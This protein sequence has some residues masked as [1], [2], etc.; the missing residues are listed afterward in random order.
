R[1]LNNCGRI[2]GRRAHRPERGD[3]PRNPPSR[4]AG[5]CQQRKRNQRGKEGLFHGVRNHVA[6][7]RKPS[8]GE[9]LSSLAQPE[10]KAAGSGLAASRTPSEERVIP[11]TDRSGSALR[12]IFA[13]LLV[14]PPSPSRVAGG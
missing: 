14:G 4:G 3:H 9:S 5:G 8:V 10:K 2:P 6:G 11:R 1:D 12:E 7:H 13:E